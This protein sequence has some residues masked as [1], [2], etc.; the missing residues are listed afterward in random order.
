MR[1]LA[2]AC[3]LNVATLYHYFPSKADLF[4]AVVEE[5]RL[6]RADPHRGAA[7]AARR[8]SAR[9]SGSALTGL[10]TWLWEAVGWR[11]PCGAC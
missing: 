3:E 9:P 2:G 11:R 6:R 5:Q 8:R 1:Q 7:G 10:V 4:R